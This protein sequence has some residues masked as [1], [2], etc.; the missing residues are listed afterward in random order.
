M[1]NIAIRVQNL[2]KCHERYDAP[3]DRLEQPVATRANQAALV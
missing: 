3:R 2:G 1:N